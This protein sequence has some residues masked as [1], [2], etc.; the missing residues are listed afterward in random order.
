MVYDCSYIAQTINA[1]ARLLLAN[2]RTKQHKK[3]AEASTDKLAPAV[4]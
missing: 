3:T 1:I 2:L 4:L